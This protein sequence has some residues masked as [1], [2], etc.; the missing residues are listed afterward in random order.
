M[1]GAK[2]C[3]DLSGLSCVTWEVAFKTA[4]KTLFFP[5]FWPIKTTSHFLIYLILLFSPLCHGT[6]AMFSRF[7]YS[8][9]GRSEQLP[10][11]YDK[12]MRDMENCNSDTITETVE[13]VR[14]GPLAQVFLRPPPPPFPS[15][16][17]IILST[18]A[19]PL[20]TSRAQTPR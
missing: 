12:N 1:G 18:S 20:P 11:A 16:I 8:F 10:G 7:R 9:S 3:L 17:S 6:L 13:A 14:A 5:N 4:L 19:C 2:S 15:S